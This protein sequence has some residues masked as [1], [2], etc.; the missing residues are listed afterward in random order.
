MSDCKHN[1][2]ETI[3]VPG[4]DETITICQDCGWEL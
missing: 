1:E 3:D 4:T 2:S